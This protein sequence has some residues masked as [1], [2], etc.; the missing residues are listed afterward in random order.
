MS[1]GFALKRRLTLKN[2][3][4]VSSLALS[5]VFALAPGAIRSHAQLPFDV[6]SGKV[7]APGLN[8]PRGLVFCSDGALYIANHSADTRP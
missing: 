3:F 5:A 6:S 1:L 7:L 4:S 8:D 2:L